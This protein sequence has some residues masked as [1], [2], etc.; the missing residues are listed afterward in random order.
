MGSTVRTA[1]DRSDRLVT[2]LLALARVEEGLEVTES[3][4]LATVATDALAAAPTTPHERPRCDDR[5]RIMR[6]DR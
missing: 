3:V 5:A 6:G 2:S 4:D 1:V